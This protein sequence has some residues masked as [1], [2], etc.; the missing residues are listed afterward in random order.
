MGV[1]HV[2]KIVQMVP[3]RATHHVSIIE[4]IVHKIPHELLGSLEIRKC[5]KKSQN[6][7][8]TKPSAQSSFHK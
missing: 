3:N 5:L 2:F 8:E 1:F 4:N 6:W 7:V